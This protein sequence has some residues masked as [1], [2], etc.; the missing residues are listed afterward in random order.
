M[1]P[2]STL[3]CTPHGA[4]RRTELSGE[5]QLFVPRYRSVVGGWKEEGIGEPHLKTVVRAGTGEGTSRD[6]TRTLDL[7][8]RGVGGVD[9]CAVGRR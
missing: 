9:R 2:R 7:S 8:G 3:A 6:R 4:G 5:L 1:C